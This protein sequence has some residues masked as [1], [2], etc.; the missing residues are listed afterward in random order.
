MSRS[1]KLLV[2]TIQLNHL[3]DQHVDI[4]FIRFIEDEECKAQL[5]H[6]AYG[7]RFEL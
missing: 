4:Q 6:L 2:D 3:R 7:L 1:I 5:T